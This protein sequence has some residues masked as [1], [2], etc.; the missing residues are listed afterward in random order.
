LYYLLINLYLFFLF[1]SY[2]IYKVSFF[3]FNSDINF[4][5]N[6]LL[7]IKEK[8]ITQMHLNARYKNDNKCEYY[9]NSNFKKYVNYYD[10]ARNPCR[11]SIVVLRRI[12]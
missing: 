1:I 4:I 10:M 8:K 9:K 2:Y 3:L 11:R 5:Y 6:I 12:R 7:K